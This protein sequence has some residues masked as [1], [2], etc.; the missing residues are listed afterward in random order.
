MSHRTAVGPS[1]L[2]FAAAVAVTTPLFVGCVPAVIAVGVGA[3][4]LVAV[5]RRSTGAQLDDQTIEFKVA[6]AAGTRFGDTTHLNVVSYNGLVVLTGEAPTI[7]V[8][9]DIAQ[10]AKTTDR[11]RTVQSEMV[12]GP[13]TDLGARSNDTVIT[14]KVKARFVE[15]DR[16]RANFVKVVTERGV[17]YLMGI[18]TRQEAEAAAQIAS[19]TSGVARVVKVFEYTN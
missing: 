10:L 1:A 7:K 18:V 15:A 19:T 17:V 12:V 16:F 2:V 3:G 4:A 9:D 5:D 11:V 14:S 8:A 6:S 13:V